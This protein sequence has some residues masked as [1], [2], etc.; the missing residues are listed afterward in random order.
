MTTSNKILIGFLVL[1]FTV[2]FIAASV[3]KSKVEKGEYK[4]VKQENTNPGMQISRA[5]GSVKVVDVAAPDA[6]LLHCNL[7]HNDS[8]R[9][10]YFQE[11]K[12]YT[13]S[14]YERNDTLFVRHPATVSKLDAPEQRYFEINIYLPRLDN[15]VLD[16]AN[17]FV[18]SLPNP[19]GSFNVT[20]RNGGRVSND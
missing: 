15:L 5:L 14:V 19:S 6:G 10:E 20:L 7:R 11:R 4:I 17:A 2:P 18:D 8:A 12:D 13:L 1:V 16:G 3:L 9:Y